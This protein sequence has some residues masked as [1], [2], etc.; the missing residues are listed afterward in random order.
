MEKQKE[1]LTQNSYQIP[2]LKKNGQ[3]GIYGTY[4]LDESSEERALDKLIWYITTSQAVPE[5][6]NKPPF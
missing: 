6:P 3:W 4:L 2:H 1:W 5:D